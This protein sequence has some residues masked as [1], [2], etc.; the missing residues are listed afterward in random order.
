MYY[1]STAENQPYLLP[2]LSQVM[3]DVDSDFETQ[4][5]PLVTPDVRQ[6]TPASGLFGADVDPL[7]P[8]LFEDLMMPRQQRSHELHFDFSIAAVLPQIQP[9][10]QSEQLETFPKAAAEPEQHIKEEPIPEK[11]DQVQHATPDRACS[12]GTTSASDELEIKS[13]IRSAEAKLD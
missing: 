12:L 2:R 4:G 7:E 9:E 6:P 10:A 3:M 5:Y 1:Q 11:D 13:M 8:N